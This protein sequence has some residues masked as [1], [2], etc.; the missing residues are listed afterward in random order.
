MMKFLSPKDPNNLGH[1]DTTFN[2]GSA[3]VGTWTE[4]DVPLGALPAGTEAAKITLDSGGGSDTLG[5]I[6]VS[7]I[8][9]AVPEPACHCRT[10]HGRIDAVAC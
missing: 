7:D 8:S 1:I 9:V 3:N 6:W 2:F 5:D 4:V 10:L